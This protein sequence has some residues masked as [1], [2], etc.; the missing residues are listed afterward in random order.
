MDNHIAIRFNLINSQ[1]VYEFLIYHY[2]QD[3]LLLIELRI[4]IF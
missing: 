2:F 3:N 1:L 4:D